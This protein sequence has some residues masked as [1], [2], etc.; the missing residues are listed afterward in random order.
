MRN[1]AFITL[2]C[3]KNEADTA[4]MRTLVAPV[5]VVVDELDDA[6]VA[7]INTCGFITSAIE[8][9]LECI[10]DVARDWLNVRA[11]RHLIVTGCLASRY[12]DELAK[13]LPEVSVFLG[14]ADEGLLID[15][16]RE[17]DDS[18]DDISDVDRQ[19]VGSVKGQVQRKAQGPSEYVKIADGCDKHCSYCTIP[20]IRGR[21]RS[22]PLEEIVAEVEGLL[23]S[24]ARE[25]VLIAQDTSRY[26]VDLPGDQSLVLLVDTL[27]TLPRLEWLRLMY[28]Q[29]EG[30]T[31][32]LLDCIA[33]NEKVCRY[34]EMPLQHASSRILQMMGRQGDTQSFLARIALIRQRFPDA[35]LRTTVIAGYPS[36]SES[37]HE[38][39]V[40]FLRAARFDYVGV[41]PYS[42][43]EGTVAA[44]QDG[45]VREDERV[46]RANVLRAVADEIGVERTERWVG[47]TLD[48]L[49]CGYDD[50]GILYGRFSGQA[51]D[52][53]GI[54]LLP[55]TGRSIESGMIVPVR[56]DDSY[57][58]DLEGTPAP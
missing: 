45:Q 55:K 36:E 35:V 16:L 50:E 29:P 7:V 17:L 40:Q 51:P 9:S 52:I 5:A 53:D 21:Y 33:R 12:G 30:M 2:G 24:G 49:I 38:E 28:I 57:L 10:F 3:P 6:D 14:V 8:E 43:E 20:A 58:F 32:D 44:E 25:I 47:C 42:V 46:R 19:D 54:I 26:G 13:E 27:V 56:I 34:F 48:T 18:S 23:A 31:D 11:G 4:H 15:R 22:R 37:E 1:V 41:F 39:L